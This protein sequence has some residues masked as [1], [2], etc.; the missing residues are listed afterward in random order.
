M[1]LFNKT[2]NFDSSISY[3]P[4]M[5]EN[6]AGVSVQKVP[7]RIYI[8]GVYLSHKPCYLFTILFSFVFVFVFVFVLCTTTFQTNFDGCESEFIIKIT[9][10]SFVLTFS[11]FHTDRRCAQPKLANK[12]H[13]IPLIIL[14]TRL[15][16]AVDTF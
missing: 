3:T 13:S 2:N 7:K 12:K 9:I 11:L 5:S 6:C 15:M 14:S 10:L 4:K 8:F 1:Y 16:V